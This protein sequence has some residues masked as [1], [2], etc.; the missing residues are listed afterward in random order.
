MPKWDAWVR[1]RGNLPRR[2]GVQQQ[3][4]VSEV[5]V[6]EA[7]HAALN[8]GDVD[9]LV[10]LS[11]PD[12]EV[13][14]PRGAGRGVQLLREWVNRANVRLEPRRLFSRGGTVVVE[15]AGQWRSAE[16]GEVIGSQS[17]AAVFAVCAGLVMSLVRYD[18]LL[19][20]LKTTGLNQ[21]DE[22]RLEHR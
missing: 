18:D 1:Y 7:W 3:G 11:H 10:G 2:S 21:S 6:V 19:E 15:Q 12:V 4:G 9:R 13:G 16:S 17:V 14:G 22:I 5:R 8:E 20:A